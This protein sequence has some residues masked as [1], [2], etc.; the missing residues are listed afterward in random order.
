VDG[1]RVILAVEPLT[2][3]EFAPYG[4]VI[5]AREDAPFHAINRGFGKR[6]DSLAAI[7]TAAA[8]GTTAVAIVRA[9]PHAL[10]FNVVMLERHLLG[11][12]AF[13]PLSAQPYLVVVAPAGPVPEASSLRCFLCAKG[14]GV[15]YAPG[16]WHH[17]LLAIGTESDF[18]VIDRAGSSG[19]VDC[20]E[21]WL[22]EG[23]VWIS[24][25]GE[26]PEGSS[27]PQLTNSRSSSRR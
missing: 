20:E 27:A 23:N 21:H 5:E 10:P 15:N 13:V 9:L 2:A 22:E 12:Q 6:F 24:G 18:L 14:Q 7:D 25:T 3:R 19:E 4:D 1:Q 8:A 16:T 17:P 11:S 26:N